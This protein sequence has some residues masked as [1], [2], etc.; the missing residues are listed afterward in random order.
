MKTSYNKYRPRQTRYRKTKSI[1][2]SGSFITTLVVAALVLFACTHIWQNVYILNLST[3]V[4]AL[5]KER[6]LIEDLIKKKQVEIND[7]CRHSRIEQL[8]QDKFNLRQTASENMF[9]LI[10][11]RRF[12]GTSRFADLIGSFK[13]V[14]DH[15]P[16]I[17]ENKAK[18]KEI[19]EFDEE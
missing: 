13:K 18:A 14:A 6:N 10:S 12:S 11:K 3:E 4:S 17:S 19:F 9:T 15:F 16:V 1:F 5:K 7:L 8:A 2:S